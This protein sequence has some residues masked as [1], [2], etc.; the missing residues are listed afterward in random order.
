M[1]E[2]PY[3]QPGYNLK[4]RTKLLDYD[5]IDKLNPRQKKYLNKFNAEYIGAGKE[6]NPEYRPLHKTKAMRKDCYDRNNARNRDI[7]TQQESMGTIQDLQDYLELQHSGGIDHIEM[8]MDL[9]RQGYI[10][11]NGEFLVTLKDLKDE[12]D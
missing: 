10:D 9:K 8:I 4:S 7:L 6:L 11:E 2:N 3:L 1:V 5:Y 12:K